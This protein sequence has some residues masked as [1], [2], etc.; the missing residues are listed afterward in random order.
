MDGLP[1]GKGGLDFNG[2]DKLSQGD[3]RSLAF[4]THDE[5]EGEFDGRMET[6][7]TRSIYPTKS[8]RQ[9]HSHHSHAFRPRLERVI[10]TGTLHPQ[11]SARLGMCIRCM[12]AYCR[13]WCEVV[14]ALLKGQILSRTGCRILGALDHRTKQSDKSQRGGC[15]GAE[16]RAPEKERLKLGKS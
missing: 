6:A 2:T 8:R 4:E 14:G 10:G 13:S 1:R 15:S 5:K 9:I 16:A 7:R 3:S 12:T 11:V